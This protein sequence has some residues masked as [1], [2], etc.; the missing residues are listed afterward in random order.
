MKLRIF[1]ILL[2]TAVMTRL[3][4]CTDDWNPNPDNVGEGIA[5]VSAEVTFK[6]LV[7][8]LDSR[9]TGGTPGNAITTF[10]N[11]NV[12][13]FKPNGEL[14]NRVEVTDPVIS[15]N[16]TTSSDALG[17]NGHQAEAETQKAS[18]RLT[19]IG[20]GRYHI[21]A[22]AN[23]PD[24]TLEAI[25][26]EQSL[27]DIVLQWNLDNVASNNQM[28]GYFSID[29]TSNGFDAPEII[30]DQPAVNL[31]AWIKRASSKVTVAF[32]GSGLKD[33][34]EIFIRS[35]TIKDIPQ[36]CYL[37]KS[38]PYN[39]SEPVSDTNSPEVK[40]YNDSKQ[41]MS[42]CPE[43][44]D[45]NGE[46]PTDSY[47]PAWPGY[48]SKTHP[49]N[50][51]NPE[52]V[53]DASLTSEQKLEALHSETTNAFY[54]Y[55]NMQG[56]G[57]EGTPTDKRQQVNEQHRKD[58]VVSYP[59]GVDPSDIAWKDAKK[60]GSYIEVQ[61]YYRSNNQTEGSGQITYRFMLGKDTKLDYNAERNYHY[62]LTLMFKGWAN[63]VDW[64]IDYKKDVTPMRFP[65]PFYISYLYNHISMIP[66][67]FDAEENVEIE[68]VEIAIRENNWEPANCKYGLSLTL[69]K[70]NKTTITNSQPGPN[71]YGTFYRYLESSEL[72][73]QPWNGF[74][75][76]KKPHNAERVPEPDPV[77]TFSEPSMLNRAHYVDYG[78][79]SRIYE[80]NEVGI[81]PY[82]VY[83]AIAEDKIH[84]AWENGTYFVKVP[85]WTRARAL[86]TRT[87]YTGNNIYFAY[88]REAK[89]N[90]KIYLSDGRVLD[91]ENDE[92]I[93]NQNGKDILVRQVRRIINP[94]GV[95]RRGN[96]M[97][98]FHVT[99]K[100]LEDD[101]ATTFTNLRS[102]GP[103]RA[104]VIKSTEPGFVSVT[105]STIEN[106]MTTD[107][108]FM[109]EGEVIT[110][111]AIEG[112][113]NSTID[114]NIKFNSKN[115]ST[116]PRYA[117]IRVEYNYNS[118]YHLIFIRQGYDAHNSVG[119]KSGNKWCV[120][121]AISQGSVATNPLDEGSLFR[122]GNWNGIKAE[123]NVNSKAVWR[124]VKPDDF[125]GNAATSLKMVDGTTKSWSDIDFKLPSGSNSFPT[126]TDGL[127]AATYADYKEF[128]AGDNDDEASWHIRTGYGVCYAD[129]ATETAS[130]LNGT[131]GHIGEGDDSKGMRG[132]F[133]Y[134][135]HTGGNLFFPIGS[136]GYGHRKHSI[137]RKAT[138]GH[139]E[140]TYYGVLR[141]A[142]SGRWG[143]FDAVND[144]IYQ[145]GVW[146]APFFLDIFNQQGAIYWYGS[147]TG[148]HVGWDINC[149]SFDF[150]DIT[151]SNVVSGGNADACFVRCIEP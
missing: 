89:V 135:T 56:K 132:C 148:E 146:N 88:Y 55:E 110:T 9:A 44:V 61:A 142:C 35:V 91:S 26:S 1:Q 65:H 5:S 111:K 150:N 90:V 50:G 87:G 76:T 103:W 23:V 139:P 58:G 13:F 112:V 116:T 99:L 39:P 130:T 43:G 28:S 17:S 22:V 92:L 81:S 4:S 133:V 7:T 80:K 144:N 131:Y 93:D 82:P 24:A 54:F 12:F 101:D 126:R 77:P 123:N 15:T 134:D 100:I 74:L 83:E 121:N 20:Y 136:S 48:V 45:P 68:K 104:Y 117:V 97:D 38:N 70:R 32:D 42:Y 128:L 6:P 71:Q 109:Y 63:D 27:K 114:F 19:D 86:I 2:L 3:C 94:K 122:F 120:G 147:P 29:N 40:L 149:G 57:E 127:R 25:S 75:S 78:L 129:G 79:A 73:N 18:F 47:T 60:Y 31:R 16:T 98:P 10:D 141:Y 14:V 37:A 124:K 62:K 33:G 66:I 143:Y 52:I 51:Y 140:T 64:H 11:L 145:Y 102:D 113:D 151:Y 96:N 107:Y 21:Y 106:T 36:T 72:D 105:N 125:I 108:T 137:L 69:N 46:I 85:I 119:V 49:I 115:Y 30:I 53:A 118:C 59:S 67:E 34:V 138:P 84:V 41:M 8:G 95:Y